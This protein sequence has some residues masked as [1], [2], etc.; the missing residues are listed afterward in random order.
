MVP[1][2]TGGCGRYE[3]S[4]RRRLN[5][6]LKSL[7]KQIAEA[8]RN[9]SSSTL[10]PQT[11][12]PRFYQGPL[13]HAIKKPDY[14]ITKLPDYQIAPSSS[15]N[16]PMKKSPRYSILHQDTS[17]LAIDKPPGLAVLSGRGRTENLIDL[18]T[19]DLATKPFTIH[20]IDADTSGLIL[21]ALTPEAHRN[22]SE[23]FRARLVTKQY[24]ALV[25][26]T[27]LNESGSINLP[28]GHDPKN[29][30][31]MIIRGE[32]EKKSRTNW[33]VQQR[34][35]GVTLLKVFPVTGRR[36]Q[37]RVHLKA[38]GYPLAVD[39]YYGGEA[40]QLS[41]FKRHY[42]LAKFTEERPLIS[43]LTLHAHQLTFTHP[44]TGAPTTLTAPLP[45][46]FR[47]TIA[48]LEKWA[49]RT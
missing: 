33:V 18:L 2:L 4:H 21:F 31:R 16:P 8:G 25:R 34:F 49:N 45:K 29:K 44:D 36:H 14:Q 7:G 28:I 47:A 13:R 39:P 20:R 23:Q 41:E 6:L 10:S 19:Q 1:L 12:R 32:D 26:G 24:L 48:A 46:D 35:T 40:L 11:R 15:Y 17:L 37:I 22:L 43:R 30:N 38:I 42:K 5:D 27:P 3:G 9:P